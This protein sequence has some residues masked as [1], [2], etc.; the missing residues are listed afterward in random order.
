MTVDEL[1]AILVGH[2]ENILVYFSFW[3][4][5]E[6]Y[7]VPVEKVKVVANRLI[8]TDNPTGD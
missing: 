4:E 1:E 3:C 7:F 6:E 5:G 8:L 2:D